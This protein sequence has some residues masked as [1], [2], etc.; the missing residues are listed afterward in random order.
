[1]DIDVGIGTDSVHDISL[2]AVK[3]LFD[4]AT[5][6]AEEDIFT[7]MNRYIEENPIYENN[8]DEEPGFGVG[9]GLH[10]Y[11]GGG[12]GVDAAAGY[13]SY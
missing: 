8:Y 6:N 11:N 4:V 12:F 1:M 7:E 10:Q 2:S 5:Y 9:F 3:P 13:N